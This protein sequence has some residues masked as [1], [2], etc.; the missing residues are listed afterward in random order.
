MKRKLAG[1]VPAGLAIA[2]AA[3]PLGAFAAG[4]K[5]QSAVPAYTI[6]NS[7]SINHIA[8]A[9]LDKDGHLDVIVS[10]PINDRIAIFKGNGDGTLQATPQYLTVGLG[11][12][13]IS[14]E[15]LDGDGFPD[16]AVT[17]YSDDKVTVILRNADGTFKPGTAY[18]AGDG[19]IGIAS[20]DLNKDGHLDLA[21]ADNDS[22]QVSL[23]Y[24]NGDGTFLAP[25]SLPVG[26]YP[27]YIIAHDFDKDGQP[28]LAV[29]DTGSANI[30][31]L[32]NQGGGTFNRSDFGGILTP[33]SLVSGDFNGDGITDLATADNGNPGGAAVLLGVG[34]G[35]F[36][37]AVLYPTAPGT[38]PFDIAAGDYDGDGRLDLA[39]SNQVV[40]TVSFFNGN[41]DGTFQPKFDLPI[42]GYVASE[43]LNE[44]GLADLVY[45]NGANLKLLNSRA[46][47]ELAF[48]A[49]T[50]TVAEN[51]GNATVTVNRT[52]SDYGQ[53]KVRVQTSDLTAVSGTDYTS[54][55]QTIVFGPGET[56]KN[57]TVPVK[58]NSV[59]GTDR[60]FGVTISG[61]TNGATLGAQTSA[62]VTIQEDDPAPDTTAPTLDPTKFAAVD[63]YSGTPDR[64]A[65]AAG[66]IGE[67]D[68]IVRAY[69]WIDADTDG[70]VDAGELDAAIPLGTSAADGSVPGADIGDLGPGTYK[71]VVS[72][73]DAA[74][75]ES[76]R[77]AAEAVTVT[78]TKGI[79]PDVADPTWPAGAALADANIT[80]TGIKLSWPA[81]DDDRGVDHYE[82]TQDGGLIASP[83]AA[84][85]SYDV[86]SLTAGTSYAFEIVAVDAAGNRSA[87]LAATV[88]TAPLV[89]PAKFSAVDNYD[90]TPDQ[91]A[92]AVD[93]IGRAGATVRAYRWTDDDTDGVVDAG[94]LGADIPLG[95]SGA[96]GSV[97]AADLG[98]LA[99]GTYKFVVTATDGVGTESPRTAASAVSVTL[100]K[101][102][103][104]DVADPTWPAGAALADAN[105]TRT[106]I[107]LSWPAADDDRGVDHYELTKDGGLIASPAAATLSYDVGSLTAGTSYAFE[108]VAV[109]AAGNRSAPLA[110]TVATS[111]LVDPAKFSAVDNYDGTPDQLVGAVDAIGRAGST[112]RAYRWT[113]D[114]TDGVVDAGELGADIALGTSGADGSVAAA[115]LGDLAPGTYKFVVTATDGVG[116]E[117]PRTAAAAVTV[118]LT[119]GIAPDVAA[120]T[121]PSGAALADANVTRTGGRLS[122]PA[123]NDDRGIDHYE[124]KQDGGL[125]ASPAAATFSYD[126]GSLTAGTSYAFEIVAVDAAGNR[127]APLA[128]TVATA[129]LVD[130]AKFSAV[131]NY[132]GTPDQLAGA[133]DAIGRAGST[134]RAYRWIDADTDG[135]VDAGEL[136]ADI[137]LGTSG[138]DGSVAAA[139]LG[140]LAPGTYKFVVTA[141]DGVGTESPRT[142][143]SAVSVTLTKGIAPDVADPTWQAGATLANTNVTRTGVKLSWPAADDDRGVDHYELTKDGGLIASPA[144][145]TLSYDVG[146]LTAG[147]SY[148]FEIVAVDAAGNRSAPLAATVATSPLVDP[149]KFSIVD[150]YYGT[151]DQLAGA[152][153][154][155]GRAGS[156]VRAYRWTDADTDGVVD[157]G[158]LGAA[159]ALGTSG[160]DGSVA[161]ADLGDLAPGTYKF[162]VTATDG[163]GTESPRTA[164][165]A[166]TVTLTKGIAPDVAAPVWQAGATLSVSA[167]T[168]ESLRLSWPAAADDRGVDHYELT[169]NAGTPI[170]LTASTLSRDIGD[171]AASTVYE[172]SIVAV[173]AAGN[174]S[175]PLTA[176]ASTPP[177][178]VTAQPPEASGENR[179]QLLTLITDAG[180][181]S[182]TPAFD[183]NVLAYEA[184]TTE[185]RVTLN[186]EP[187]SPA[188]VLRI[189]GQSVPGKLPLAIDLAPGKNEIQIE[190]RAA[191]GS[192]RAYSLTINRQEKPPVVTCFG[193]IRGHWAEAEIN[194]A[195]ALGLVQGGPEGLYRPDSPV[196]RAEW[197]VM[198]ARWLNSD[199]KSIA[200]VSGFADSSSIPAWA[201]E[202]IAAALDSGIL[203]G[204]PDG[205][206]RPAVTIS[207]AETAAT[208][209]RA[210]KWT[211]DSTTVT[212]FAD[213]ASIPSWA[214]P[215][216]ATA[217]MHGILSGKIGN[218]F[219]PGAPTT[220]AEAAAFLVRLSKRSN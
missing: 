71:Y 62:V 178:S 125:I 43:D 3:A 68:A 151:P 91:L 130:P 65:G 131:D 46:E 7:G 54:V 8:F 55:D 63:N 17:S 59:Y 25:V 72:A 195:C 61:P 121:W 204:Y 120:P 73:E 34:D 119:K 205:T 102:I 152:V 88:A 94:E 127:S 134:V 196:T 104:P 12:R 124:L 89:D 44:D 86:G 122:W 126:V 93:A 113:D 70:V 182:L 13:R 208:L 2:M 21:I 112:V 183:M 28:D 57:V 190:V 80:R 216:A 107:K 180:S 101:G 45:A 16:L 81:A 14:I 179:V 129:P 123:A 35:S 136:G 139:D 99:P 118:T 192:I 106:G 153:D 67:P 6:N 69:R 36:R 66:A 38:Y 83:A 100:T 163:V 164:A 215:Y 137:A 41:A 95:T 188:A 133:V 53:T 64:L 194:E 77:T 11:P 209:V 105:I 23:L 198:I 150:N 82:L 58:D 146:S 85:L 97:A 199:V 176:T 110:A 90:G 177:R 109:D 117:S 158:E 143:A 60:T 191:N 47:G 33:T 210:A 162:V 220:R 27:R 50:F 103:A 145:A 74:G 156:T 201:R 135:V 48:S 171:L 87:P 51:G 142:A 32:L 75:N 5:F 114:D 4:P 184:T 155:I 40:G 149:A 170:I 132:D 42:F 56:T 92:G 214:K 211:T 78:L 174:R 189:N 1:L 39:V 186:A 141:T 148:A 111:P 219:E 10:D 154:A 172:F 115:D 197:A 144:A 173:D 203:N 29:S 185:S 212:N 84:T 175:A 217:A 138:A 140:D 116:I 30:S 193:D 52:G 19:P 157:T 206:F 168:Y 108:I 202:A 181:V 26:S 49:P 15:D 24:G 22:H 207:R 167:V 18:A 128:A 169:Q 187:L 79:A 213:D 160:A 159:I 76:P 98:D 37:T 165:A 166:V 96:D 20:V 31:V 9:D 147:K 161:A 200:M 218:R